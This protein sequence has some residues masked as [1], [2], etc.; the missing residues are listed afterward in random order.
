MSSVIGSLANGNFAGPDVTL[1]E[2][3][4][5]ERKALARQREVR[6]WLVEYPRAIPLTIF[7]LIACITALSV[8]A[9]ESGERER[10]VARLGE[11]AQTIASAI[12]R[13]GDAA[14]AYLQAGAALFV[15]RDDL[16]REAFAGFVD[17][18]RLESDYF[19][20]EGIGW[21][22]ALAP[23]DAPAFKQEMIAAGTT[24]FSITPEPPAGD[25]RIVPVTFL[26]PATERNRRAL[27]YDMYSEPVRRAAMDEAERS[28]R[29][30]ASGRIVLV[31]EGRSKAPGFLIYM[32]V[33]DSTNPGRSL[34]GFIYSPFNAADFLGSAVKLAPDYPHRIRL[35]DGRPAPE[36]VLAETGNA[37]AAG[38]TLVQ[39]VNF[40]NR[41]MFLE[42]AA[43]TDDSLSRLGMLTLIFGLLVASL[44]L[45]VVRLLTRQVME[46][47][48]AL[49]WL[50][51]QDS[52]RDSLTRE[53]NHRVK[54]ALA[55]IL[56]IIALTRRRATSLDQFA[57]GLDG[58][59]RAMSATHDLLTRSEWGT[60]SLHDVVEAELALYF[61]DDARNIEITG[62]P[63]QLAPGDALSFGMAVHELATNAARHGAFSTAGGAVSVSWELVKSDLA[64]VVWQESG[65]AGNRSVRSQGFGLQLIER[66]VAHE[67]GQP[68]DI[69]FSEEGLRCVLLVPVRTPSDFALR[70]RYRA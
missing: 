66:I 14:S 1:N 59:V 32:P 4:E 50:E 33:Y 45:V 20:A 7:A 24:R 51:E 69:A 67:L 17:S 21:A 38:L 60:T 13:R 63:V 37:E 12:E 10:R 70:A 62:P 57:D 55:N 47:Q 35:H 29:P 44:L 64:R 46:D 43:I 39:P 27:G 58:R 15:I 52:I 34:R 2:P 56:S 42:I 68:V 16:S 49:A 40:A 28:V 48:A 3:P 41:P 31:Q 6:R 25:A 5:R 18:L 30:T 26:H 36:N 23:A 61:A 19:G 8:Y 22:R 65:N 11:E 53:L 9:I 54:N